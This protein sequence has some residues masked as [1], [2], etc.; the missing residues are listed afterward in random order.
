MI[1]PMLTQAGNSAGR[2]RY[3]SQPCAQGL[4]PRTEGLSRAIRARLTPLLLPPIIRDLIN[5]WTNSESRC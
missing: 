2:A 5:G 1:R 3:A 4:G